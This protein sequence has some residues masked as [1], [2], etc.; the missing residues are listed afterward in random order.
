VISLAGFFMSWV[1]VA[2]GFNLASTCTLS[3]LSKQ[4]PREWNGNLSMVI[5]YS[6]YMGRVTGAVWG[7]AGLALGM[8]VYLVI[9]IAVV[10]IGASLYT[11]LWKDLKTKTG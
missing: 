9:Q 4:L 10:V 6:N 5:Q 1:L 2:L 11:G 7:G 8:K 3:L